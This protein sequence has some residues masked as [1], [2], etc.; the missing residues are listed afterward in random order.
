MMT[1]L[2]LVIPSAQVKEDYLRMLSLQ[3]GS[4]RLSLAQMKW[5]VSNYTQ[6][7]PGLVSPS[8][9]CKKPLE[10]SESFHQT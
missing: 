6:H 4:K 2:K 9:L 7:L 3:Q 5:P 8:W 10:H 1:S